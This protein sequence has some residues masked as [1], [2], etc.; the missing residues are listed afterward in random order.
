MKINNFLRINNYEKIGNFFELNGFTFLGKNGTSK[1][2][3]NEIQ[4]IENLKNNLDEAE[5]RR[6]ILNIYFAHSFLYIRDIEDAFGLEIENKI[7]LN[8]LNQ[9]IVI[10]DIL[11]DY[12]QEE[13]DNIVKLNLEWDIKKDVTLST[14]LND[15]SI[16][17]FKKRIKELKLKS[18]FFSDD[19]F[20]REMK[21]PV[22]NWLIEEIKKSDFIQKIY[23]ELPEII[24]DIINDYNQ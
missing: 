7:L 1:F 6:K 9:I 13:I 19:E 2:D 12:E 11:L 14:L 22:S 24:V 21:K 4:L 18:V 3:S 16:D 20:K 23:D 15:D 5:N 10:A 8:S 17:F